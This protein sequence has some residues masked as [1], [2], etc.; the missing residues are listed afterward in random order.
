MSS[1]RSASFAA[2]VKRASRSIQTSHS[3]SCAASA[4]R[5]RLILFHRA[6]RPRMSLCSPP[7]TTAH[8]RPT[9]QYRTR[10]SM[11]SPAM[12]DDLSSPYSAPEEATRRRAATVTTATLR[13]SPGGR[14]A[15]ASPS[16]ASASPTAKS[17]PH[18]RRRVSQFGEEVSVSEG[19]AA[20]AAAGSMSMA[21]PPRRG[22]RFM[23]GLVGSGAVCEE[24]RCD[25]A[26]FTAATRSAGAAARGRLAGV[27]PV[28]E[29]LAR[30]L[31][32]SRGASSLS[33]G[34]SESRSGR[35]WRLLHQS[36]CRCGERER[37]RTNSHVESGKG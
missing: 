6:E 22:R 1:T 2:S 35:E 3:Y 30:R 14:D 17:T 10:L 11:D 27:W 23:A 36:A 20:G 8:R 7:T 34:Y 13:D 4:S 19:A 25:S 37:A 18:V 12:N 16:R 26:G 32:A 31:T 28:R 29:C 15:T 24:S 5:R 21:P 9:A 33:L